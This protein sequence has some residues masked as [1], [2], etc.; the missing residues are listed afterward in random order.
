MGFTVELSKAD[1]NSLQV[2]LMKPTNGDYEITFLD[3]SGNAVG[4]ASDC[5]N[6]SKNKKGKKGKK[7]K[8]S[9]QIIIM[10]RKKQWIMLMVKIKK[11][12]KKRKRNLHN[13]HW[14]EKLNAWKKRMEIYDVVRIANVFSRSRVLR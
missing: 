3:D 11:I 7:E 4:A 8:R 1:M 6:D 10:K 2:A 9:N 13:N 14:N 5:D 12:R